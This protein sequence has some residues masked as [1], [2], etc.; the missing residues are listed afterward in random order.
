MMQLMVDFYNLK[1]HIL[2]IN[3]EKCCSESWWNINF[4]CSEILRNS[5]NNEVNVLRVGNRQVI[6]DD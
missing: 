3:D 6:F 4:K 5:E 1:S 2:H